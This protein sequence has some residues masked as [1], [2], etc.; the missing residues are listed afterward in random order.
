MRKTMAIALSLALLLMSGYAAFG[1]SEAVTLMGYEHPDNNRVWEEN[2]F[3]QRM[4]QQTGIPLA[5][6]QYQD[7]AAYQQRLRSLSKDDADLPDALFKAMLDP[8][9]TMD[10]YEKGVLI[11]LAPHLA[12]HA[13]NFSALMRED[14][15]ILP[16]ISLPGGQIAALPFITRLPSQNI[17]WINKAWLDDLK[18]PMPETIED[19]EAVLAAFKTRDPNKNG[20]ADEIPLSFVGP[21]D[22][23]Y[24]AH[25]WGLVANDY[26]LYVETG[27]VRFMPLEPG[28]R[29]FIEWSAGMYAGGFFDRDAFSTPDTLRRQTDAKAANRFGAFFAPLPTSVVPLE[30]SRQYEA[31]VPLMHEGRR[32]YRQIASPVFYGTF[33]LTAACGDVP[34]MLS[35]VDSLYAPEGAILAS[36]GLEGEDYVVDGD[37]SWRLLREPGDRAYLSQ[38]IIGSDQSAPGITNEEFQSN[39]TDPGVRQLTGQTLTVSRY[40]VLPFPDFPLTA[41]QQ[42]GI[43]PLQKAIGRYVDESIG[44]FVTGEWPVNDESMAEFAETLESLGVGQFLA[45]WQQIYD[46]GMK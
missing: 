42:A 39:Y 23:K 4:T 6:R 37:G 20:R 31:M 1:E 14:P 22:L 44:R 28:F 9:T 7:L 35:W 43:L 33:A 46:K 3:F 29:E 26:N 21:Y 12:A 11:D 19:L 15:S 24:L 10:L 13:P 8:Q 41:E 32:V 2:L 5:F 17:L 40:A 18:L 30:W 36:I 38:V 27:K 25:A 16:A 34:G 45:L